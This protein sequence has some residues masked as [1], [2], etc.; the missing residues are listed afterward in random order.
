MIYVFD[1]N[2]L[3]ALFNS[4]YRARFPSLWAQFD[5]LIDAGKIVSTREVLREIDGT[6]IKGLEEW[7]KDN[8]AIFTVP[9]A[10]EGAFVAQIYKVA[11]FQQNIERRKLVNGGKNADPFVIAKAKA[12]SGSV[13]TLEKAQP[14]SVKI[15][16]ICEYFGIS[17]MTLEGF[18]EAENWEF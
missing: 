16:T 9:S 14:N 3:F 7:C 11:H 18:M 8:K 5:A 15:P 2:A 6:S 4:Y 12:A 10:E 13:V 17:C 1:T